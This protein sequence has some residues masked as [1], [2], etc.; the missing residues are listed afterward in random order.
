MPSPRSQHIHSAR[1][2]LAQARVRRHQHA[3][4]ATLL[5]WAANARRR[6]AS[7]RGPQCAMF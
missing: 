1:V 7:T 6:A 4:H 3:F 5:C 2:Y